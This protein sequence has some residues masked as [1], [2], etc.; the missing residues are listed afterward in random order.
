MKITA[1]IITALIS[2][3]T[4]WFLIEVLIEDYL[5][6]ALRNPVELAQ[7]LKTEAANTEGKDDAHWLAEAEKNIALGKKFQAYTDG[8][9]TLL[10]MKLAALGGIAG[11][12]GFFVMFGLTW[13]VSKP[14]TVFLDTPMGNFIRFY[15]TPMVFS[16]IIEYLV[17]SLVLFPLWA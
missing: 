4:N 17:V 11:F 5:Q 1:A 6:D 10:K 8:K 14:L 2:I 9:T 13:A 12:V 3:F 16:V 15:F 7:E